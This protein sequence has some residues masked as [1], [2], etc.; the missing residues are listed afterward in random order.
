MGTIF[1]SSLTIGTLNRKDLG[2][3]VKKNKSSRLCQLAREKSTQRMSCYT[4]LKKKKSQLLNL[5]KEGGCQNEKPAKMG[6]LPKVSFAKSGAAKRGSLENCQERKSTDVARMP[7]AMSYIYIY[8]YIY[9]QGRRRRQ[10]GKEEG[11]NQQ[12][13]GRPRK[14]DADVRKRKRAP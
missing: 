12:D 3:K 8:I 2:T 7:H 4:T 14:A 5:P 13:V 10:E 11:S 6:K 1:H 9:A